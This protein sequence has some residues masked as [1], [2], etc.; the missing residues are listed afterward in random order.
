M[1]E[2]RLEELKQLEV[3]IL[4]FIRKICN[5]N[6]IK[7]YLGYGTLIGAIRHRGFIP[8]DDD[9]DIMVPVEQYEKLLQLVSE[10]SG[11]YS[12]LSWNRTPNY[13]YP[14]AKV[15][16]TKTKLIELDEEP[17]EQ[18]GVYIDIFPIVGIPSNVICYKLYK[19]RMKALRR[20]WHYA[21]VKDFNK[22]ESAL[23]NLVR[24]VR[25]SIAKKKGLQYWLKKIDK[26]QKNMP[27]IDSAMVGDMFSSRTENFLNERLEAEFENDFFSVPAKY[28]ELLMSC[29]GDYM[30]LP[31]EDQR[32]SNHNFKAWYV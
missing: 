27:S 15:I 11:R 28:H 23:R 18:L 5:D 14:F 20:E 19:L 25:F 26:L 4:K 30:K 9:I 13:F 17:I 12:V 6:G 21:C 32:V 7:Y 31:L 8:W 24:R 2:I 10:D 22:G 16:D 3:E 1:T 29:Y